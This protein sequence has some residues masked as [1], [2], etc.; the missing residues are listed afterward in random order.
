MGEVEWRSAAASAL[1]IDLD[2]LEVVGEAIER[3]LDAVSD[4]AKAGADRLVGAL[5]IRP[6]RVVAEH[7][8]ALTG[9]GEGEL[10]DEGPDDTEPSADRVRGGKVIAAGGDPSLVPLARRDGLGRGR[11]DPGYLGDAVEKLMGRM[12]S[13]KAAVI[14]LSGQS[15]QGKRTRHA[16][17]GFLN[18]S[19]RSSSRKEARFGSM[20]RCY[21]NTCSPT[22]RACEG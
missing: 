9:R 8:A 13:R 15:A 3:R 10:E 22:I 18:S 17:G 11:G 5:E 12:A 4:E 20:R 1:G 21:T 7:A 2:A 16:S 6:L 19:S 14:A